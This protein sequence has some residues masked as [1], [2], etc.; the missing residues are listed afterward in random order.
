MTSSEQDDLPFLDLVHHWLQNQC[1]LKSKQQCRKPHQHVSSFA[2]I[3]DIKTSG[4]IFGFPLVNLVYLLHL[5][6]S[7]TQGSPTSVPWCP[8][9][10]TD[11]TSRMPK[12]NHPP[13]FSRQEW[14][15]ASKNWPR[16]SKF[17]N[18]SPFLDP[19][20]DIQEFAPHH[21]FVSWPGDLGTTWSIQKYP[22]SLV[23]WCTWETYSIISCLMKES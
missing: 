16:N 18:I 3:S 22:E 9:D 4:M 1:A 7:C 13:P 23:F 21:T 8:Q 11:A 10:W 5:L 19:W 17:P 15:S 2:I 20:T 12:H 6:L 14:A